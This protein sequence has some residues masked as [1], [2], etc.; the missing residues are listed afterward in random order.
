MTVVR[1]NSI[2]GINSITVQNG[3]AL[4]IHDANGN[5]IRNITSSTGI[6]TFQSLE[7]TKGTGDLTVGVSTFFV[8]NNFLT[9]VLSFCPGGI[10]EV[11]V[12]AIAFDLD[13]SFVSF[14]HIIRLLFIL[15]TVPVFLKIINKSKIKN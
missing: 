3:Q 2:A 15:F 5:L 10:Y 12:I 14:H 8:D 6:S 13:P 4:N 9:L 1:P 11:A 7:I